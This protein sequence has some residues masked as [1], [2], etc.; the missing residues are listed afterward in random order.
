MDVSPQG[1]PTLRESQLTRDN[2]P[3]A[4]I[5]KSPHDAK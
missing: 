1:L 3:L 4:L 2:G 5:G